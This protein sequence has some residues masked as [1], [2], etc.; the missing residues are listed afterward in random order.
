MLNLYNP[1][2]LH[3]ELQLKYWQ[4]V[5]RVTRFATQAKRWGS[6]FKQ[7]RAIMAMAFLTGILIGLIP[8][9]R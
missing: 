7:N 4:F 9:I 3:D 5:L 8:A 2:D 6:L 1:L